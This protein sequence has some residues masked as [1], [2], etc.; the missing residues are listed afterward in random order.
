MRASSAGELTLAPWAYNGTL[1][2]KAPARIA[3]IHARNHLLTS[4]RYS[5]FMSVRATLISRI[6][7][8][9]W[10]VYQTVDFLHRFPVNRFW[11]RQLNDAPTENMDSADTGILR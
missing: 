11:K 6:V 1:P 5:V 4:L 3:I 10:V 7:T 9:K 8:R 2:A